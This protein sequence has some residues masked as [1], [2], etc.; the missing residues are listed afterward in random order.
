M[1]ADLPGT[2]RGSSST[3]QVREDGRH[4]GEARHEPGARAAAAAEAQRELA[5][6]TPSESASCTRRKSF[7]RRS[8]IA[9]PRRPSSR[10]LVRTRC[11]RRSQGSRSGRRSSSARSLLL[12]SMDPVYVNFCPAGRSTRSANRRRGA[13]VDDSVAIS[14]SVG[15][16]TAINSVVDEATRNVQVRDVPEHAWELRPACSSTSRFCRPA[17]LS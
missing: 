9:P 16:I 7:R 15:K 14:K 13:C 12:Q 6:S 4:P 1:S 8:S 10:R 3:R 2:S 17:G 11:A 5:D